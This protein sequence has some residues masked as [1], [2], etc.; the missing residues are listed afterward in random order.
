MPRV[1]EL[2]HAQRLCA[3]LPGP[4]T[5]NRCPLNSATKPLSD[6]NE[7]TYFEYLGRTDEVS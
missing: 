4:W 1:A 3:V 5:L 6:S 7:E 2:C